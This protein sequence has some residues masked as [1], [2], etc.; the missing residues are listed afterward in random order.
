VLSPSLSTSSTA[1]N[2]YTS[3]I[4]DEASACGTNLDHA[5][6]AVGYG[7]DSDGTSYYIIRNSW[8]ANWGEEGY[9]RF[10]MTGD[11]P[12]MCGVQLASFTANANYV[13][14]QS[15]NQQQ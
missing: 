12:G 10:Q 8:S 15:G 5:I 4:F 2:Y 3:G 11:G 14:N 1:F 6:A 7:T 9:I 13:P